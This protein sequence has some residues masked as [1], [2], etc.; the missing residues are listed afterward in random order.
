LKRY[1]VFNLLKADTMCC[2]SSE[3][4]HSEP[5]KFELL[6]SPTNEKAIHEP[7]FYPEQMVPGEVI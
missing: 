4:A 3:K 1:D 2:C 7:I 6:W 5:E